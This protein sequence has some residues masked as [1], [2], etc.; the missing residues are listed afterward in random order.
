RQKVRVG[1]VDTPT[2]RSKGQR[3]N[4]DFE[5]V[6]TFTART[7]AVGSVFVGSGDDFIRGARTGKTETGARA[8]G[9]ALEHT[10]PAYK[11]LLLG[12]TYRGPARVFGFDIITNFR[13]LR[14]NQGKVIG[15]LCASLLI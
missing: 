12:G 6:D 14:D 2:L 10:H 3:I 7:G 15:A 4:L 11:P 1:S 9:T 5:L 13:A 8:I